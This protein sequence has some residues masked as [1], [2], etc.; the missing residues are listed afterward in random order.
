LVLARF[1]WCAQSVKVHKK[2]VAEFSERITELSRTM[3]ELAATAKPEQG[4]AIT[5]NLLSSHLDRFKTVLDECKATL[6]VFAGRKFVM[7]MVMGRRDTDTLA[8][9]D[10]RLTKCITDLQPA[11]HAQV[12]TI[13]QVSYTAMTDANAAIMEQLVALQERVSLPL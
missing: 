9:L 7:R 1:Y 4:G 12:L 5:A 6:E 13:Q 10:A 2:R 11:L 8:Q 3:M